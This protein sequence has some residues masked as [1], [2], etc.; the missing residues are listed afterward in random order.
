MLVFYCADICV[1]CLQRT[2]DSARPSLTDDNSSVPGQRANFRQMKNSMSESSTG[3]LSCI[4]EQSESDLPS[5]KSMSPA[6]ATIPSTEHV[7]R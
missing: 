4:A 1:D 3:A 6:A 7:D 5:H 2:R